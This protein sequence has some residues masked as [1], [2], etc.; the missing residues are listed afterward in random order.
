MTNELQMIILH[1][2][3]FLIEEKTNIEKLLLPLWLKYNKTLYVKI[4][5][6]FAYIKTNHLG[7]TK[8]FKY[9]I[10]KLFRFDIS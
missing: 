10:A 4:N 7:K 2:P 8:I 5:I 3:L 6:R 1:P 9:K